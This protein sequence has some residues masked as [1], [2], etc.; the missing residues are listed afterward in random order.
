MQAV[1]NKGPARSFP[2]RHGPP[3]T[4]WDMTPTN[5]PGHTTAAEASQID[6][7]RLGPQP[8][9]RQRPRLTQVKE[10]GDVTRPYSAPPTSFTI[11]MAIRTLNPTLRSARAKSS[12]VTTVA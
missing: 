10:P 1:K 6:L 2:P 4:P 9:V 3:Q 12:R 5:I 7:S 8:R 11:H